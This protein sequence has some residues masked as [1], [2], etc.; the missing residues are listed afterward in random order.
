M[1]QRDAVSRLLDMRVDKVAPGYAL[2]SMTVRP[3]MLNGVSTCHGGISYALADTAFAFACNSHGHIAVAQSCTIAYPAAAQLGD[4]LS[5][6]CR[7][8]H[9]KGRTGLYDCTV[10]NQDGVVVAL[11]RGQSRTLPGSIVEGNE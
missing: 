6:E 11:F 8:I 5:A 10:T 9:L 2:L 3:D 4:R 1:S 7:E